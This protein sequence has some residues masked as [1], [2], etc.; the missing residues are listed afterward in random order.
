MSESGH[1]QFDDFVASVDDIVP[2][3]E[4]R[5]FD[6]MMFDVCGEANHIRSAAAKG[7]DV[8]P[9]VR[10]FDRACLRVY[11][12]SGVSPQRKFSLRAAE[13]ILKAGLVWGAPEVSSACATR[14]F[15]EWQHDRNMTL[16]SL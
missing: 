14:W 1:P 7:Q 11:S 2:T 15:D 16:L 12:D 13:W 10:A 8:S 9:A 3:G 4:S 6:R 5:S